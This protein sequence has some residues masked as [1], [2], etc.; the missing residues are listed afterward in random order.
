MKSSGR[1]FSR[2]S[3][4]RWMQQSTLAKTRG[5]ITPSVKLELEV[6]TGADGEERK[7]EG[8]GTGMNWITGIDGSSGS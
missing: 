4:L 2:D 3:Q 1:S 7:K 5:E 8:T 6:K